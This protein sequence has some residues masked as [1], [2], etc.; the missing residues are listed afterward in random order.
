MGAAPDEL[1]ARRQGGDEGHEGEAGIGAGV[2]DARQAQRDTR[3]RANEQR[4]RIQQVVGPAHIEPVKGCA[5]PVAQALLG[6]SLLG[7][8]EGLAD[9]VFGRDAVALGE[10]VLAWEQGAPGVG[11]RQ[12]D[13]VEVVRA[14]GP[15]RYAEVGDAL[16]EVLGHVV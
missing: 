11:V 15:H 12:A 5:H 7:Q 16:G 6:K 3:P 10:R 8:D 9:E 14:R 13:D 2:G 1:D 4:A